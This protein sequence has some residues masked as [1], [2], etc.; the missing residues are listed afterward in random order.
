LD[1]FSVPE[2]AVATMLERSVEQKTFQRYPIRIE[3]N[4]S[5]VE[6]EF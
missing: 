2:V 4:S 6:R 5:L 3:L 1:V